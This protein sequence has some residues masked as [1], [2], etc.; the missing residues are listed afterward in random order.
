MLRKRV[1]SPIET[2]N[3]TSFLSVDTHTSLVLL[4]V[5]VRQLHDQSRIRSKLESIW[6]CCNVTMS[7]E[8]RFDSETMDRIG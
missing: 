8:K 1:I 7:T 4:A 5:E 2:R 3:E 6:S